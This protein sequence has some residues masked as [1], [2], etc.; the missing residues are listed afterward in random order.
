MRT[1]LKAQIHFHCYEPRMYST[2]ISF[3]SASDKQGQSLNASLV[4]VWASV[5]IPLYGDSYSP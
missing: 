3:S 5:S 1:L 2:S 4:Y